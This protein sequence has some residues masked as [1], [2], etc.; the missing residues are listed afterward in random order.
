MANKVRKT[1]KRKQIQRGGT[2]SEEFLEI[3][4]GGDLE[5]VKNAV[6]AHPDLV[7]Q[8]FKGIS[9]LMRASI[10]NHLHIVTYLVDKG[11]NVNY[12]SSGGWTTVG[13]TP[14]FFALNE[15]SSPEIVE[16]LVESGADVNAVRAG[17]ET[18]L[19]KAVQN[20]PNIVPFLLENGADPNA[21][22]PLLAASTYEIAKAL[23]EKGAIPNGQHLIRLANSHP[24][25]EETLRIVTL[26]LENG[27]DAK[28][29][30]DTGLTVLH[31]CGLFGLF[32]LIPLFA[33]YGADP[34]AQTTK[35][36][37]TPLHNAVRSMH[38]ND[39]TITALLEAGANPDIPDKKGLTPI[40]IAIAKGKESA[41]RILGNYVGIVEFNAPNTNSGPLYNA[42]LTDEIGEGNILGFFPNNS[43]KIY[44]DQG[45][46]VRKSTNEPNAQT[47][48]WRHVLESGKN[49][50]TRKALVPPALRKVRIRAKTRKGGKRGSRR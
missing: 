18:P 9:P 43:G 29:K 30:T 44:P 25:R 10:N 13:T 12:A 21:G 31:Y 5:A 8:S 41:V 40:N 36:G 3:V 33:Q 4:K 6:D 26:L 50:F 28:Y 42:L 20:A 32:Q 38:G 34:N 19:K 49:P 15:K 45:I 2:T 37:I 14:L 16:F 48:A 11:A 24:F 7:N 47:N 22:N 1:R 27:A 17:N 23:I 46:L 35:E 39:Q